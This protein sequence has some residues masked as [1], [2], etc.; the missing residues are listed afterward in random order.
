MKIFVKAKPNSRETKVELIDP[1]S[2]GVQVAGPIRAYKVSVKAAPVDGNANVAV[3][4]AL[5][6]HFKVPASAIRLTS[7]S[8]AKI[9]IFSVDI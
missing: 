2:L 4:K 3:K 9:K 8:A 7:G 6:E 1:Q 5:A